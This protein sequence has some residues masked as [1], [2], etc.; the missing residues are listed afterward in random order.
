MAKRPAPRGPLHQEYVF[1]VRS[2][3]LSY[4]YGLRHYR[5]RSEAEPFEEQA[6]V[7][8]VTECI[9]PDR[10][11]G[12]E[13]KATL[14]P[15]PLLTDPKPI[16]QDH[17]RRKWIGHIRAAKNDFE[18]VIWLPPQAVWLLGE[19][20][21]SGLVRSMLANAMVEPRGMNRV[22]SA[23]FEGSEFDPVEYVG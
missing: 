14:Y 8:F 17:V 6:A 12:R 3:S 16:S 13:G 11:K 23:S 18:T 19:A 9:W 15:E 10:F 2:P 1:H 20:M 22:I 21:A 5:R 7:H 4:S